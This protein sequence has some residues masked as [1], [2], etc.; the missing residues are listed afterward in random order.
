MKY[1]K[2]SKKLQKV[3]R[4]GKIVEKSIIIL[5][6]WFMHILALIMRYHWNRNISIENNKILFLTFQKTTPVIQ[7]IFAK[8]F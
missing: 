8:R 2:L 3:I 5:Y 1:S 4:G 6:N 7:N